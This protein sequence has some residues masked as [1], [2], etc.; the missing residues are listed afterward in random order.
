MAGDVFKVV[1]FMAL[2]PVKAVVFGGLRDRI[3]A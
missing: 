1:D 3:K 2:E